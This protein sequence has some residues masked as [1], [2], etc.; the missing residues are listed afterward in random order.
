MSPPSRHTTP[1]LRQ[2]DVRPRARAGATA[3]CLGGVLAALLVALPPGAACADIALDTLAQHPP[4]TWVSIARGGGPAVRQPHA[5]AAFDTRRGRLLVFGSDTHG[6]DWDNVVHEFDPAS[7]RWS[8]HGSPS[9][10]ASYRSDA[11]GR[12]IA[13]EPP[14]PWAMHT[15]AGL[16][17]DPTLDALLVAAA[18]D[19]NPITRSVPQARA[20]PI[21]LYRLASRRWEPMDVDAERPTRFFAA[22]AAYDSRRDTLL[23]YRF[24]I[25]ELGPE[26]Q[27]WVRATTEGHHQL[28][29]TMVYD[30]RHGRF[31]V[32]GNHR[33]T[34][35]VWVYTPGAQA[36]NRGRWEKKTPGGDACPPDQ[37]L[38][39]AFDAEHGVFL[40]VVDD[41]AFEE[42][43]GGARKRLGARRA[44]T[45]IYDLAANRYT[46]LPDAD[47]PAQGMNF[48]MAYDPRRKLFLL[49]SGD[50]RRALEVLALRLDP[51][52]LRR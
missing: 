12:A 9:E 3:T 48:M 32:F 52:A 1:A 13:G 36:G 30:S 31:A 39:A 8:A 33:D 51:P 17:Y 21:W 28:H 49:V 40:L 29:H 7:G 15:F 45:F 19:H 20:H 42:L 23:A 14:A 6:L 22:A 5:G 24:G 50:R 38:P 26:R 47:L 18:P 25:W 2:F 11:H 10:R 46:R 43:P 4:N 35:D 37:H 16:A 44:M 34:Q 41:N 27:R